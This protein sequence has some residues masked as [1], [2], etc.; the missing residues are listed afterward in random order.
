M[1]R[2]LATIRRI[3]NIRPI[4][5]ADRIEV[6]TVGGW[7]VVI[8]K[9]VGHQIGDLVVYCE[10]DSFLPI[11]P[12]FEFLRK[13]SYKKMESREGF[14]LKTMRF[15]GVTSQGL[16]IP[17]KDAYNIYKRNTP[18]FDMVWFE[19]LD[20][21]DMLGIIK[22]EAP[23]P[24]QLMGVMKGG[25][26]SFLCKTDEPRL[27]NLTDEY[28]QWVKNDITFYVTEKL[29]GSSS[30]FYLNNGEFGVCSRNIDLARPEPFVPGTIVCDDGIERP[31]Q[32]NT[33]WKVARELKLEEKLKAYYDRTG[34]NIAVQGELI[35][36]GVQKN[37][38]DIKGHTVYF[39]NV[40]DIDAQRFFGLEGFTDF[41][42]YI[43]GEKTV[44]ILDVNFKLPK[45]VNEM[46]QFANG[47]SVLN[48]KTNREGIVIRSLDRRIS[49]KAISN[50][51]LI[52][53]E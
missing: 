47:K 28:Q 38:Y 51:Y 22:Y 40:F 39:F 49:F 2:K 12:E 23:I 46:L 8:A 26:P 31:K 25:F 33:F 20:V 36:E 30:T 7:D 52:E 24:A 50:E 42:N 13:T 14:R 5:G 15:K 53:N 1:E 43:L 48:P 9:D 17:I 29:D 41:V 3:S 10:I 19:G 32:E 4:E 6:A 34:K 16:I 11:E 18:N 45:T 37:I 44:P 21:T 35:G 27:Q